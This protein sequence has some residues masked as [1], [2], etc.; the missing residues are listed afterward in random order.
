MQEEDCG[1]QQEQG[2]Q[3]S[4]G[5][6][7]IKDGPERGMF[8]LA[9]KNS[10]DEKSGKN[11]KDVHTRPTAAQEG[12]VEQ[13]YHQKR[14]SSQA[15]ELNKSQTTLLV[16]VLYGAGDEWRH[17]APGAAWRGLQLSDSPKL[18]FGGCAFRGRQT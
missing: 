7:R 3:D 15:V 4:C 11:K 9:P 1:E 2:R 8:R 12:V 10:G 13:E 6:F 16:Y 5:P 17:T 14:Q 18:E